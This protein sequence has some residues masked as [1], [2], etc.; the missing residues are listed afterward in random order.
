M[1]HTEI[2]SIQ[3][4]EEAKIVMRKS[5][6]IKDDSGHSLSFDSPP[7]R[8]ISLVPSLTHTL[9]EMGVADRIVGRT[10]F[11]TE[12]KDVVSAIPDVGGP[13][14]INIEK[15]IYLKPDLVLADMEENSE[16]DVKALMKAGLFTA[17]FLPKKVED[18][19][20]ILERI[21][22]LL[23]GDNRASRVITNVTNAIKDAQNEPLPLIPSLS[24]IWKGPYMSFAPNTYIGSI[25]KLSGFMNIFQKM[26]ERYF[27][28][29]LEEI[30]HNNI[31]AI[32]LPTEPYPFTPEELDEISLRLNVPLSRSFIIKGDLLTWYGATTADAIETLRQLYYYLKSM[33]M[34][35]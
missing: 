11:C 8:I 18:V 23:Q 12:P 19:P 1:V 3:K 21:A 14:N 26:G 4:A 33:H 2:Q 27:K 24:L 31:E 16:D 25:L 5:I 35:I 13:K 17:A 28:V 34:K 29:D 10:S 7:R 22:T 32:I 9:A 15:V 6:S 30:A 20:G